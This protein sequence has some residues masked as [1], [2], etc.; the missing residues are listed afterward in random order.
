M[1]LHSKD[2]E[3]LKDCYAPNYQISLIFGDGCVKM[4]EDRPTL[5]A[6]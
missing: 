6:T 1:I 3:L 5:S 2:L 4:N